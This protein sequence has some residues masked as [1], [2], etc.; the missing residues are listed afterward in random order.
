MVFGEVAGWAPG[1]TGLVG[2][3]TSMARKEAGSG[4]WEGPAEGLSCRPTSA[5][6]LPGKCGRRLRVSLVTAW[7]EYVKPA[8]GARA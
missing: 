2:I 5:G 3:V 1:A 4:I 8:A 7:G 6:R